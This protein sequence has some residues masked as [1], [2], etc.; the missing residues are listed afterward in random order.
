VG[1]E[2][3]VVLHL[4]QHVTPPAHSASAK[5]AWQLLLALQPVPHC[6]STSYHW[7]HC[8][9]PCHENRGGAP[10]PARPR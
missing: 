9:V 2:P 6:T 3:P 10:P 4:W 8:F 5:R 1:V 7:H